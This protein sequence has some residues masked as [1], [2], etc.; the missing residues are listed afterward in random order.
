MNELIPVS[1]K[2]VLLGVQQTPSPNRGGAL[3]APFLLL[4]H[5]TAGRGFTSALA[6]LCNPKAKASAHAL[7]GRKGELAQMVPLNR[8]AWHAGE[9][10]WRG[11]RRVNGFSIGLEIE[12]YGQLT[13]Y[14]GELYPWF[15]FKRD[16]HG[17]PLS[18]PQLTATARPVPWD[19]VYEHQPP[20]DAEGRTPWSTYWHAYT[21]EQL[22]K[23]EHLTRSI[24]AAL[25]SITEMAG[26]EDVRE[27]KSDPGPAFP[28]ERYR[29]LLERSPAID[30]VT[31]QPSGA[32]KVEPAA[33]LTVT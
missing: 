19:E 28:W 22:D 32:D 9:S 33:S 29:A 14:E 4:F 11:R 1:K 18:P 20:A 17:V 24:L 23:L 25:P 5:F 30:T 16:E 13:E 10:E 21:D 7:S 2:G 27:G 3:L 15:A 8:I 12:N 26:H 31:E 6:W